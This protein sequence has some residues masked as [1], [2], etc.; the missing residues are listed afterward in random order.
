MKDVYPELIKE[1][2]E[3]V[4]IVSPL[5]YLDVFEKLIVRGADYDFKTLTEAFAGYTMGVCNMI[6]AESGMGKTTFVHGEIFNLMAQGHKVAMISTEERI[7]QSMYNL[8]WTAKG[9]ALPV[10]SSDDPKIDAENKRIRR[11]AALEMFKADLLFMPKNVT[12]LQLGNIV[13]F[14]KECSTKGIKHIFLDN[15]TALAAK[16]EGM[17]GDVWQKIEKVCSTL[18]DLA[19]TE[20]IH[21]CVVGHTNSPKHEITQYKI[22]G[23]QSL[24]NMV[25]N[26]ICM[27]KATREPVRD[28]KG[29]ILMDYRVIEILKARQFGQYRDRKIGLQYDSVTR[30]ITENAGVLME[31]PDDRTVPPK[32]K[33]AEDVVSKTSAK[34]IM[35]AKKFK[36]AEGDVSEAEDVEADF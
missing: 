21:I 22:K 18:S 34:D 19:R 30:R 5:D 2:E 7:E 25:D 27:Y 26:I 31:E 29:S 1:G 35:L 3:Q 23:G 16:N 28:T 14:I 11:D 20:D 32:K 10:F 6:F 17:E 33:K 15:I 24:A 4:E 8:L 12:R 9:K 36:N 13:T